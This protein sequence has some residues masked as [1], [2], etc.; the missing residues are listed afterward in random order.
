MCI[1]NDPE[2]QFVNGSLGIVIGFDHA[3]NLPRVR[4]RNGR[5]VQIEPATWELRDG[6]SKRASITQLPL[7]LAWAITVHKSQGMTLDAA[8]I[9]LSRAFVEGMGYVAL[10]R[11]R[12]LDALSLTGL[13]RMALQVSSEARTID[14]QLRQQSDEAVD[15]LGYLR[16]QTDTKPKH[17]RSVGL[18]QWSERLATMRAEYPN[19]YQPWKKEDD[20]TLTSQFT[21]GAKLKELTALFVRHPGS[22][23]ARLKKHFGENVTIPR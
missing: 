14:A 1:R 18:P 6:E 5:T 21:S 9:D 10:S 4:L 15:R 17:E 23:R 19:A 22:I 16:T 11:V 8:T 13:N 12:R 2:H 3:T 7:R 20:E